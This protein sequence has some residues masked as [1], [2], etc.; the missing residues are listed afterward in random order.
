M[1]AE[2]DFPAVTGRLR[3]RFDR[4]AAL[5]QADTLASVV[6]I[7]AAADAQ[8][9]QGRWVVGWVAY[10]AAPAFD[11]AL[12][13]RGP[14]PDLPLAW[15]AAFDAPGDEEP[16]AGAGFACGQW[17]AEAGR[18]E[19]EAAVE[20]I[21]DGIR[22]GRYYQVN[23]SGR[24]RAAFSGEPAAFHRAL[25]ATQPEGYCAY[26]D[27][28]GWQLL[29]ASPELFF[30]W[31]PEGR[32]Q[33]RPMK[34]TAPRVGDPAADAAAA[35]G[36]RASPKERAENL[37]IVDLLRNDLARIAVTG[38]VRVP[39]LFTVEA[40]PTAWQMTSA[41]ECE[42]RPG[43]GLA[44]VFGAL[45]P[46]GSVTGAP[47]V[48][49]MAAIADLERS[50]RGAYCG[51][52][53]LIRPGGHATF[54]VAIRSVTVADGSAEAGIGS[55]ITLDSAAAA[56]FAEWLV[57]RRF[58]LRASADFA[59]L[60][61]LRLEEGAYWLR[62][63]H[64]QRLVASAEHFG[65]MLDRRRVEAALDALAGTHAA[66]AW[67]VRL[68]VDRNGSPQLEAFALEPQSPPVVVGLAA[69]PLDGGDERLRHKT[70]DRSPYA[71]HAPATGC[72]D[73]LLWN[74]RGE[75][76]EFTRGNLVA[77]IAGRRLTPPLACGLLPGVLRAELLA[78]GEIEEAVLTRDDLARATRLWFINSVRGWIEVT[79]AA[80]P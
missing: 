56:E 39:Q 22:D 8:A 20:R 25:V 75:L 43:T 66:G 65:F 12:R 17:R 42:T 33:A 54:N 13:V 69:C 14:R 27:G 52:I 30:D 62:E 3:L 70:S 80:A 24:Y 10:E 45:F 32:L 57:K 31:Q 40:L 78:A 68:Q 36:L 34:G 37:M 2:I 23:L 18:D 74:R 35:R 72:F 9:R 16:A 46:S 51:A 53:G 28:G 63:R 71:A 50:P 1:F 44:D 4:P 67:R 41:I 6:P 60:E 48:A 47:K 29:S 58:L 38:S 26:I 19:M 7:V 5:L 73:T 61:T 79:L 11:A 77:E 49:A 76:T 64:L 55:G 21:R 59:L 15:F